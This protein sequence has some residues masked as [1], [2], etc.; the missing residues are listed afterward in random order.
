[1]K[2]FKF[3]SQI[4][5]LFLFF[6]NQCIAASDTLV[7]S[8][9]DQLVG[10][11]K[12][13]KYGVLT[14]DTDYADSKFKIEWEQ[15]VAIHSSRIYRLFDDQGNFIIGAIEMNET[16]S[17]NLT[18]NTGILEYSIESYK[19]V[20]IAQLEDKFIDRL[21][22]GLNL[23][24]GFTKANSAQQFTLTSN[25]GYETKRWNLRGSINLFYNL[26]TIYYS[27]N[28]YI[29]TCSICKTPCK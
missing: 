24:Y 3:S 28:F 23:G 27:M 8:T 14:F 4:L 26:F 5:L 22:L 2:Y 18:I 25:A 12:S 6:S 21:S 15:V 1:M 29:F 10:E 20:E 7:S 17:G 11:L 16:D 9:G 13:M 19:I